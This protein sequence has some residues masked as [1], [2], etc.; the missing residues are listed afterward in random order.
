MG[1]DKLST[2]EIEFLEQRRKWALHSSGAETAWR[3]GLVGMVIVFILQLPLFLEKSWNV[4]QM[5]SFWVA[6]T[7]C[8]NYAYIVERKKDNKKYISIIDKVAK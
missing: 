4:L 3:I 8:T 7:Y 2:E 1:L 5:P 6:L